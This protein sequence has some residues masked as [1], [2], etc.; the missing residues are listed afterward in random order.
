MPDSIGQIDLA[1]WYLEQLA[2]I[3]GGHVKKTPNK[4]QWCIIK[5]GPLPDAIDAL[6]E[7]DRWMALIADYTEKLAKASQS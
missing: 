1:H 4:T 5:D 3:I 7:D 6:Q 2:T